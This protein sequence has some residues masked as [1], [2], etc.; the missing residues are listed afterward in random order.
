MVNAPTVLLLVPTSKV[1]PLTVTAL[2]DPPNTG[3][4]APAANVP[5]VINVPP[6]YVLRLVKLVVPEPACVRLPAP[7]KIAE[8]LAF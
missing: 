1:P 3:A 5:P 4:L 2:L 7:P 8:T 6:L